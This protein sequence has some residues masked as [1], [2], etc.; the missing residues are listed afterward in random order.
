MGSGIE[1]EYPTLNQTAKALVEASE[2]FGPKE[3][4][5][6][7]DAGALTAAFAGAGAL[8]LEQAAKLAR[9][10]NGAGNA[11]RNARHVYEQTDNAARDGLP[12]LGN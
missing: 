3:E 7:V 11:V 8:A 6:A 4:P 12:N 9:A 1:A 10:V 5:P 2:R